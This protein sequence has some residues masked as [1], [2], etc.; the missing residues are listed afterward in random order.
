MW[1]L[2][3]IC[4]DNGQLLTSETIDELFTPQLGV[5]A[6]K[7]FE[8]F[9]ATMESSGMFSSRGPGTEVNYGLGA[10]LI[11]SDLATGVKTGT[12]FW[13]GMPNLLWTID[14]ATGLSLYY[15]SNILPFGDHTSHRMQQ[16]FEKE[17][18]SRFD[19]VSKL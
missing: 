1:I 15:A 13:S 10:A 11:L 2:D 8:K 18:Y 14:R 17:M 16:L 19:R 7:A 12:L 9:S 4:S 3:S 5:E 6:Q